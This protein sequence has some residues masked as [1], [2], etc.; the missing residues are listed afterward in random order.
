MRPRYR[1]TVP[2][3]YHGESKSLWYIVRWPTNSREDWE[4]VASDTDPKMARREV[5]RLR[6]KELTRRF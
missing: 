4:A 3:P 2:P 6:K 5:R 1:Y